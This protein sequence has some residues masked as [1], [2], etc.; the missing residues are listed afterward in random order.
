MGAWGFVSLAYGIVWGCIL[1]Y[2]ILLKRR[3]M[4]AAAELD[5]LKSKQAA[6]SDAKK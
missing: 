5:M 6:G 4:N 2:L 1:V 3:Y